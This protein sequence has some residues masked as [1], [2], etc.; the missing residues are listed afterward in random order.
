[1]CLCLFVCVSVSLRL[2]GFVLWLCVSGVSLSR[3]VVHVLSRALS[4]P[5][6]LCPSPSPSHSLALSPSPPASLSLSLPLPLPLSASASATASVVV[7]VP[8]LVPVSPMVSP[9]LFLTKL[10][11]MLSVYCYHMSHPISALSVCRRSLDYLFACLSVCLVVLKRSRARTSSGI[12]APPPCYQTIAVCFCYSFWALRCALFF[13]S[14]RSNENCQQNPVGSST[15]RSSGR[16]TAN[17]VRKPV[18]AKTKLPRCTFKLGI[19]AFCASP[20][21]PTFLFCCPCSSC[22]LL[23][24]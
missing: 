23:H 21:I 3:C 20:C 14:V 16:Q 19:L 5:L 9:N 6:L 22:S 13:L 12:I 7:S 2:C 10:V 11:H 24:L 17:V 15:D 18:R 1:M 4:R 8:V